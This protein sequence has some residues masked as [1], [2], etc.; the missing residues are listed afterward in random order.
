[1]ARTKHPDAVYVDTPRGIFSAAGV[2]FAATEEALRSYAGAV[3]ERRPLPELIGDATRWLRSPQTLTL[4]ALPLLLAVLPPLAAALAALVVLVAWS[5][6]GP[7]FVNRPTAA[8]L[9]GLDKPLVQ[10]LYFLFVLS[11]LAAQAEYAAVW[12]GLGGF[13]L[14]RWGIAEWAVKPLVRPIQR[15]IYDLPVADQ[16]LRAFI[17]RVALQYGLSLP[18]LDAIE[19]QMRRN[20]SRPSKS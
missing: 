17:L 16:V 18:Q 5:C 19:Q 7:A 6:V 8:L 10:A 3:L 20:R 9:K 13:I 4:W 12:T 14:L 2:W 11:A 1:M 15:S